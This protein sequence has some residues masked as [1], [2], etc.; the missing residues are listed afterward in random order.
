MLTYQIAHGDHYAVPAEQRHSKHYI[1]QTLR[2]ILQNDKQRY[3][4]RHPVVPTSNNESFWSVRCC[5]GVTTYGWP[6][7]DNVTAEPEHH[8]DKQTVCQCW[9]AVFHVATYRVPPPQGIA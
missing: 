6:T 5:T 1:E 2:G 9:Y 4:T 7:E 8:L 3:D